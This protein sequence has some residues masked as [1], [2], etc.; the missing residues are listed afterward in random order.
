MIVSFTL[1]FCNN[2]ACWNQSA[3]SI[4][5]VVVIGEVYLD[6]SD[7]ESEKTIVEREF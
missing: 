4:Y 2:I 7:L 3:Y 5:G 6:I 1:G